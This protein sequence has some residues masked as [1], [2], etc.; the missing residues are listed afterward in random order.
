[1]R[2]KEGRVGGGGGGRCQQKKS[3]GLRAFYQIPCLQLDRSVMPAIWDI[4]A[5]S[6]SSS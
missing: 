1:M 5:R 2:R 3:I 4:L 6:E